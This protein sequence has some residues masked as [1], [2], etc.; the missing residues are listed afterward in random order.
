MDDIH[1]AKA[2]KITLAWIGKGVSKVISMTGIRTRL[3]AVGV[4]ELGNL[5]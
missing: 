3:S 1:P 2:T 4:I 5:A